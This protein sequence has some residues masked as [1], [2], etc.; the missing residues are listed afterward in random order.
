MTLALAVRR[1]FPWA[2]VVPYWIAQIFGAFLGAFA[3]YLVY[4]DGLV[5]TGLPN[6]WC[7]K[8]LID[9]RSE[10]VVRESLEGLAVAHPD[11]VKVHLRPELCRPRGAPVQG[12]LP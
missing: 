11:L 5:A 2:K 3:V 1:G 7:T 9:N 10:N 12:R 4:R 8:K 6:V